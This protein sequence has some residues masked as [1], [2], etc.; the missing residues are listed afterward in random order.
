FTGPLAP[1]I[2]IAYKDGVRS[3][4]IRPGIVG[5]TGG[6]GR[7]CPGAG[8][9]YLEDACCMAAT[10]RDGIIGTWIEAGFTACHL[11]CS[12]SIWA[13]HLINHVG[14]RVGLALRNGHWH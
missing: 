9:E 2:A 1:A 8:V 11:H 13:K 6:F 10:N 14:Y 7:S 4:N 5:R 12:R 3:L